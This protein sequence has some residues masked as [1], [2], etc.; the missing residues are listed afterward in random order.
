MPIL[1]TLVK[2]LVAMYGLNE[3]AT[4]GVGGFSVVCLVVSM[5][6]LMPPTRRGPTGSYRRLGELFMDFLDL[7]GKKFDYENK[8]IRLNPPGHVDKVCE[9][10]PPLFDQKVTMLT[11]QIRRPRSRKSLTRP[12]ISND[13]PS[14]I[15]TTKPTTLPAAQPNGPRSGRFL[16]T[17]TRGCKR[18]C[19]EMWS[20]IRTGPAF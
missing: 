10:G 7:Y 16:P 6:Q 15:R 8:A 3:P 19:R 13:Y 9:V 4:G 14:S 11:R 1:A 18:Q 17:P 5:L 12:P 2:H 20:I